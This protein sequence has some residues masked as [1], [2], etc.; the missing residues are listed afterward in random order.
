MAL[1]D[2]RMRN[3]TEFI[4][5]SIFPSEQAV[6]ASFAFARPFLGR[7]LKP[8]LLHL[9]AYSYIYYTTDGLMSLKHSSIFHRSGHGSGKGASQASSNSTVEDFA[10]LFE[11]ADFL[12]IEHCIFL[13]L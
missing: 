5:R 4:F 1:G 7:K 13:I 11:E 8:S 9:R 3:G 2:V 6:Q 10:V 12:G